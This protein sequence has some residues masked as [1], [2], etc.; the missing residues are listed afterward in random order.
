MLAAGESRTG[1]RPA[2]PRAARCVTYQRSVSCIRRSGSGSGSPTTR[3]RTSTSSASPAPQ[4]RRAIA[5]DDRRAVALDEPVDGRVVEGSPL[6]QPVDRQLGRGP[7]HWDDVTGHSSTAHW[8][9]PCAP[10]S[11]ST[12][13]SSGTVPSSP[14]S[15]RSSRRPAAG[16]GRSANRRTST[17]TQHRVVEL[18][19]A[20]GVRHRDDVADPAERRG[21]T[22][23]RRARPAGRGRGRA[24]LARSAPSRPPTRR[25]PAA[26]RG[27]RRRTAQAAQQDARRDRRRSA[28]DRRVAAAA[29]RPRRGAAEIGSLCSG[30][31]SRLELAVELVDGPRGTSRRCPAPPRIASAK[32][33]SAEVGS[34]RCRRCDGVHAVER[35]LQ[36]ERVDAGELVHGVALG[37]GVR[38]RSARRWS[39]TSVQPAVE[40]QVAAATLQTWRRARRRRLSRSCQPAVTVAT[41]PSGATERTTAP[42]V[43]RNR[44]GPSRTVFTRGS[45]RHQR[46]LDRVVT[47]AQPACTW[48]VRPTSSSMPRSGVVVGVA[49]PDPGVGHVAGLDGLGAGADVRQVGVDDPVAVAR[50]WI[51]SRPR[52]ALDLPV[53]VGAQRDDAGG[54]RARHRGAP[55]TAVHDG[56][57]PLAVD[58]DVVGG[59]VEVPG[60]DAR[61]AAADLGE[62]QTLR[63]RRTTPCGS[64]RCR[65]PSA[66]MTRLPELADL[67]VERRVVDPVGGDELGRDP[68]VPH[69]LEH[70]GVVVRRPV[71][72]DVAVDGDRVVEALVALDEL[73]DRDRV[74]VTEPDQRLVAARPSS[75]RGWCPARPLRR[76]A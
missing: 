34:G 49:H 54:V 25:R 2:S 53:V 41:G 56:V 64:P 15:T 71:V 67:V 36:P 17:R 12:R 69:R 28:S 35:A 30:G 57:R 60:A 10:I 62:A 24:R 51:S 6:E 65:C 38:R 21:P 45:W 5:L 4:E 70:V 9:P 19:P 39:S 66:S 72:G 11:V 58:V 31:A 18:Q 75:P 8:A 44:C 59:G 7:A 68:P 3:C 23:P 73:L 22:A 37:E 16:S 74:G 47:G 32:A 42:T 26:V 14:I 13:A 40:V 20:P 46:C 43:V 55:A 27:V 76:A 50:R 63:A 61:R 29:R 1:T 52:V 48:T 33:P